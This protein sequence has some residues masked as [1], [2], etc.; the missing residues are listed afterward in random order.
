MDSK[1]AIAVQYLANR[2]PVTAKTVFSLT[3]YDKATPEVLVPVVAIA[4]SGEKAIQMLREREPNVEVVSAVS[5]H[6]L[7]VLLATLREVA[8]G[9]IKPFV[10]QDGFAAADIF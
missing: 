3:C 8:R 1:N 10:M 9:E 4:E 2:V 6:D 7:M 5:A